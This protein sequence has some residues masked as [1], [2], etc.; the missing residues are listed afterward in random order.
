MCRR[1]DSLSL[2]HVPKLSRTGLKSGGFVRAGLLKTP[3]FV[4]SRP[5]P[6]RPRPALTRFFEALPHY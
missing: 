5:V 6:S 2:R 3:G 4:S 1:Q